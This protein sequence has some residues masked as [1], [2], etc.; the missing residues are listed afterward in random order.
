MLLKDL[1]HIF[2]L[3]SSPICLTC[4]L[5][6]PPTLVC[7]PWSRQYMFIIGSPY[8][9]FLLQAHSSA[10][11]NFSLSQP[12]PCPVLLAGIILATWHTLGLCLDITFVGQSFWAQFISQLQVEYLPLIFFDILYYSNFIM[13][14]CQVSNSNSRFEK[15]N[16]IRS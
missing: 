13:C 14:L 7:T 8:L 4:H 6:L 5:N 10:W 11:N 15:A 9:W 12:K 16:C 2:Y 1:T 3:V